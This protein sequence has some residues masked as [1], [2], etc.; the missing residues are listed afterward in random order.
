MQLINSLTKTKKFI[1]RYP[2]FKNCCYIESRLLTGSECTQ[3][4][5]MGHSEGET[6]LIIGL[7]GA[8][9]CVSTNVSIWGTIP[10]LLFKLTSTQTEE[11]WQS[12]MNKLKKALFVVF[13]KIPA[14][15]SQCGCFGGRNQWRKSYS[16]FF[17][18]WWQ[19]DRV[20]FCSC[21]AGLERRA[22]LGLPVIAFVQGFTMNRNKREKEYY[23]IDVG[24]STF[25]V[26]KRYQNLRPIGSGAQ[27]IVW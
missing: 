19:N 11:K 2:P 27:G 9:S 1:T 10:R 15:F 22:P 7:A 23:S 6:L 18:H 8:S 4:Q 25:M 17:F 24:D 3:R 13:I 12:K 21:I 5:T 20:V 16:L 14:F 26:I